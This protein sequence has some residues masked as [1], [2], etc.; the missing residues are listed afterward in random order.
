MKDLGRG[1][2]GERIGGEDGN[3]GDCTVGERLIIFV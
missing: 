2:G 3:F 1:G